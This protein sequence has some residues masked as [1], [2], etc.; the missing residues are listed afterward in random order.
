MKFVSSLIDLTATDVTIAGGKATSLSKLL[1]NN[2][3]VPNGFVIL[4][5][6]FHEFI[7]ANNLNGEIEVILAN[8]DI[9]NPKK[10]STASK[11]IKKIILNKTIPK[12]IVE[13]IESTFYNLD[14]KKVAVRSS[15]TDED[16]I[17]SSW[18]GCF[19]SYLNVDKSNLIEGIKRVW[20]SLYNPRCLMYKYNSGINKDISVGVIVQEM[21]QAE[22]SGICFTAHPVTG[23]KNTVIIEAG[24]GI[25]EAIVGG[26]I[27]PDMYLVHK[28]K[29]Q[30]TYKQISEQRIKY[31]QGKK[32][33]EVYKVDKK[34]QSLQKLSDDQIITLFEK[35]IFI[36]EIFGTYQD[37]EWA[38]V[39]NNFY[40][41]QSRAITT[42]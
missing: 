4:T 36:E 5:N 17:S 24:F 39:D 28:H 20:A 33:N 35:C 25:G 19:E 2:N 7:K 23:D 34:K 16:S 6:A 29:K 8:I 38:L 22:V 30:I 18:A 40:I 27:T 32:N 10:V 14:S 9:N 12:G 41:T 11:K 42:I 37:I 26:K 3:P 15:A 21:I 1:R 13:E 31:S